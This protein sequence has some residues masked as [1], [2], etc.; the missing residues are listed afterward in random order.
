MGPGSW[1]CPGKDGPNARPGKV[2]KPRDCFGML[3]GT[4]ARAAAHTASRRLVGARGF[5]ARCC[6]DVA[7]SSH[8]CAT[9]RAPFSTCALALG[10]PIV[11]LSNPGPLVGP[12][13]GRASSDGHLSNL[14]AAGGVCFCRGRRSERRPGPAWEE[15][16]WVSGVRGDCR[17]HGGCLAP[18]PDQ[19]SSVSAAQLPA[20]GQCARHRGCC[21]GRWSHRPVRG[22][23]AT[24]GGAG[25]ARRVFAC[26]TGS[27]AGARITGCAP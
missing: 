8:R 17:A 20:H 1:G 13:A 18:R 11:D 10:G 7:R 21:R 4:F 12:P 15:S 25:V 5:S 9:T 24:R 19:W 3:E 2:K 22:S 26:G 14:V 27:A 23:R 16:D 6:W